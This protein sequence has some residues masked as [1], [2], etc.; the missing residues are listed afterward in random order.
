[1]AIDRACHCGSGLTSRWANDARGIP[2]ARVC[3]DCRQQ[4]LSGYRPEVFTDGNY[5]ADKPTE[6]D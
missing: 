4:K 3:P 5:E 6:E 1:M 2:L